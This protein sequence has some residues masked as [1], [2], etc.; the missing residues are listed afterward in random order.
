ML[1]PADPHLLVEFFY[2]VVDSDDGLDVN[3]DLVIAQLLQPLIAE[4]R[5]SSS[6]AGYEFMRY[7][8]GGY[9]LRLKLRGERGPLDDAR[10]NRIAPR[11]AKFSAD[12]A[13][14]LGARMV[15]GDF[16][17]RL[18]ARLEKDASQLNAGGHYAMSWQ[19][20][21]D[22]LYEDA[23]VFADYLAFS[24]RQ[25]DFLVDML[26]L[27]PGL[28]ARKTLVRLLLADLLAATGLR[29]DEMYYVIL[30]THRQWEAYFGV[31]AAGAAQ[32]RE[33]SLL[34]GPRFHAFLDRRS[35]PQD[36]AE[37]LPAAAAARYREAVPALCALAAR[38]VRREAHGGIGNN[39]A[40][41]LLSFVHLGHNRIGLDIA[42]ELL[43]TR[44]MSDYY[45]RRLDAG[46]ISESQYWVERN[47]STY[48]SRREN[49][50]Y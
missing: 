37:A 3:G 30:F 47:L 6:I 11:L 45:A 9:H 33:Q 40:L 14:A 28:R 19:R 8:V 4:L 48:L 18:Y 17:Q 7:S 2:P 36:S 31:D 20:D 22:E 38:L 46:R 13:G 50:V 23:D 34:L 26:A 21:Q 12:Q 42:Q 10:V 29:D 5:A 1:K 24:E 44:L 39:T 27:L 25:C 49:I 41:R 16:S 43:F 15:L 32:C 35:G